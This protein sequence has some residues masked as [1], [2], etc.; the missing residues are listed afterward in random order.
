MQRFLT[1]CAPALLLGA[2]A[3][4]DVPVSDGENPAWV[5][6]RL[7][8]RGDGRAAPTV[9]PVTSFSRRDQDAMR[10]S[11]EDLLRK[12]EALNAA[13]RATDRPADESD[14]SDFVETGR[15]RTTP[16]EDE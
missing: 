12:R 16:P 7:D 8:E 9:V 14:T 11:T 6:D 1:L 2:C 15:D 5:E 4:L 10:D 13:A 3:G